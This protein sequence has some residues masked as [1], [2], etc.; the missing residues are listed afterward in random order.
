MKSIA[1]MSEY[2]RKSHRSSQKKFK[3]FCEQLDAIILNDEFINQS[4]KLFL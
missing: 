4:T 3:D 1:I 2:L